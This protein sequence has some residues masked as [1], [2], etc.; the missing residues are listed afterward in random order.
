[1]SISV[2]LVED[3]RDLAATVVDYLELEN[4]ACDFAP[5]GA[6]GLDL[7]REERFD[8]LIVD[9]SMP[10]MDGLRLCETLRRDGRD[11]P[12][13]IL[14]A[15]GTLQDKLSGF[16]AGA[17][18][19]L[20][21]P[22][23]VDELVAR[24]RALAGRRSAR[25]TVRQIADLRIDFDRCEADRRGRQLDLTPTGWRML[26]ALARQSP[27]TLT[28]AQLYAAGWLDEVPSKNNFNVQL[29]RLRRAVDGEATMKLLHTVAGVGI[30]LGEE[31]DV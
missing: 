2:L 12:L 8:V 26:E 3:D 17:D 1:M 19:Y 4:I 29:H 10:V 21:K 27:R 6:V 25:P 31:H 28:H 14:T 13:L 7:A 30:R 20:T 24:V 18:D 5:N 22:F 11:V 9:V 15:R 23:E 16:A